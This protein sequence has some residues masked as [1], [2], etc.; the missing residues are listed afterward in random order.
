MKNRCDNLCALLVGKEK[1]CI[2]PAGKK[3]KRPLPIAEIGKGR[4]GVVWDKPERITQSH[5]RK[6]IRPR[7]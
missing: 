3:R 5:R 6:T 1:K 4:C 7:R 2:I